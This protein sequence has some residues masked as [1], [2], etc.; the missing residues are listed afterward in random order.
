LTI[1]D[2]ETVSELIARDAER[3]TMRLH[4]DIAAHFTGHSADTDC[5][6]VSRHTARG[7]WTCVYVVLAAG[8]L[9]LTPRTVTY[10]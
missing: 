7:N 8:S 1:Q 2:L 9:L 4:V 6:P 3:K 10:A 5:E